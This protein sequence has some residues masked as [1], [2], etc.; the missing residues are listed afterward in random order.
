MVIRILN[1]IVVT[2]FVT[3][4]LFIT[5]TSHA[6]WPCYDQ[7]L[8]HTG[9]TD[10]VVEYPFEPE[11]STPLWDEN[12][13]EQ[14]FL[15]PG[16]P[17]SNG[18]V[19]I[20]GMHRAND[21]VSTFDDLEIWGLNVSDGSVK[22]HKN[23]G[24]GV[25]GAPQVYDNYVIFAVWNYRLSSS[26]P[27]NTTLY[28][29]DVNTGAEAWSKTFNDRKGC[30]PAVSDGKIVMCFL[31]KTGD[32]PDNFALAYDLSSKAELWRTPLN[33]PEVH[34]AFQVG[35]SNT[36]I[37][38]P[39]IY[40]G[41][42]YF[43][44]WNHARCLD[45]SDGH[46]VW[47]VSDYGDVNFSRLTFACLVADGKFIF[48]ESYTAARSGIACYALDAVDGS[49]EWIWTNNKTS[50][51]DPSISYHDGKIY[52]ESSEGAVV[53]NSSNGNA[54]N[55]SATFDEFNF[56]PVIDGNGNVYENSGLFTIFNSDLSS[57]IYEF[58]RDHGINIDRSNQ[59]PLAYLDNL[60][61]APVSLGNS[62]II[63]LTAFRHDITPPVAIIT[64]PSAEELSNP[65]DLITIK[66]TAT[67]FNLTEWKLEYAPHD[68][69][70]N[71]TLI[72]SGTN[73][74]ED[75]NLESYWDLSTIGDGEWNITLTVTDEAGLSSDD[76]FFLLRDYTPP[77]SV[78][79]YP[80]E[81]DSFEDLSITITGT[82]SDN[83]QLDRVQVW[84]SE[85]KQWHDA[86]GAET[87][88]Y[89]WT[90][91]NGCQSV[92][93]KSRAIDAMGNIESP[94]QEVTVNIVVNVYFEAVYPTS[95]DDASVVMQ[96]GEF[97]RKVKV[98]D[99]IG[100]PVRDARVYYATADGGEEYD[101]TDD[102]GIATLK[103]D[104]T[105]LM[106]STTRIT[107]PFETELEIT[108]IRFY[109]YPD[110]CTF[111][112]IDPLPLIPVTIIPREA[113]HY[114]SGGLA[115]SL[116]AGIT[117]YV[118]ESYGGGTKISIDNME[119]V[120]LTQT[121]DGSVGVGVSA[122]PE[123]G[124]GIVD[125]EAKVGAQLDFIFLGDQTFN[126]GEALCSDMD[127]SSCRNRRLAYSS[128]L[129]TALARNAMCLSNPTI[130][131]IIVL[132]TATSYS[133]YLEE[134][135]GRAGLRIE[136]GGNAGAGVGFESEQGAEA[137]GVEL[138]VLDGSVAFAFLVG[139]RMY[140]QENLT[141][142]LAVQE[143]ETSLNALSFNVGGQEV[144]S[145]T[146]FFNLSGAN[147]YFQFTEEVIF[148][149]SMDPTAFLFS[150]SDGEETVSY[151][152]EDFSAIQQY[153]STSAGNLQNLALG[154]AD[155]PSG[156]L[157]LGM[158]ACSHE[159]SR[160]VNLLD[161][162]PYTWERTSVKKIKDYD[163]TLSLDFNIQVITVGGS[164]SVKYEEGREFLSEKGLFLDGQKHVLSEYEYD[165]YVR[166]DTRSLSDM[167]SDSFS[168]LWTLLLDTGIS[169]FTDTVGS[170]AAWTINTLTG[171]GIKGI[172]SRDAPSTGTWAILSGSD[173][174]I[175]RTTDI[176]II[177]YHPEN[178]PCRG[179]SIV[180]DCF[181]IQPGDLEILKTLTLETGYGLSPMPDGVNENQ[182][183]M[184]F[185]D[186]TQ[187]RWTPVS[188]GTVSTE[189]H[190]VTAGIDSLCVYAVGA[191]ITPPVIN[192]LP[193]ASEGFTT[194]S[195]IMLSK[196]YDEI[197]EIS[198]NNVKVDGSTTAHNYEVEEKMLRITP[199]TPLSEG[200]HTV[201]IEAADASG[202][203]SELEKTITC[204]GTLP[205]A[206]ITYPAPGEVVRR[207]IDIKGTAD[208]D[209]FLFYTLKMK[210]KETPGIWWLGRP[211]EAPVNAGTL[212]T[213]DTTLIPDDEYTL[214]LRVVDKAGNVTMVTEDV[215][216]NN[217]KEKHGIILY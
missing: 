131:E 119:N 27:E 176:S 100:N 195:A 107:E 62:D 41:K 11:W 198:I 94:P 162:V 203:S 120:S 204:D 122:G 24:G 72:N 150:I 10:S 68:D 15:L 181:D 117:G 8:Q 90:G 76:S 86:D 118:A 185:W 52:L 157:Q 110:D 88:S 151:R 164:A 14:T 51:P 123:F 129:V 190:S 13:S 95:H 153:M 115:Q 170:T 177:S 126:F 217:T 31:D 2:L 135:S 127:N 98:T 40:N 180:G 58:D 83:I 39:C 38:P 30:A 47:D 136:A 42:V 148:N 109:D 211:S 132:L 28:V 192:M 174:S 207:T 97:L 189:N 22:W 196:I 138:S 91:I 121:F 65:D 202:N 103:V 64:Q 81:G 112:P 92:T 23:V 186:E 175:P 139:M 200:D 74:R 77:Q 44:T 165:T 25:L 113:K 128:L 43:T 154:F 87:W 182:L 199:E 17:V 124:M 102:N 7:N 125:A 19:A 66:G 130:D 59:A 3:A 215:I 206:V 56:S 85:S 79:T 143:I 208:D 93:F 152:F 33:A 161:N 166:G 53:L 84:D 172:D 134:Q 158:Q 99:S 12:A 29:L 26:D 146:E 70:D 188:G 67:D 49:E 179:L 20:M 57:E 187:N 75:Q 194:P 178:D 140:H 145:A 6:N 155:N 183:I 16:A 111:T 156:G 191:D 160:I 193:P 101:V 167:L 54:I 18:S 36:E 71:R 48:V 116:K 9:Y 105:D 214:E 73:Y 149:D 184:F 45:I 171:G 163:F 114:W 21:T 108:R 63:S 169:C 210:G 69:P 201:Y 80:N 205:D 5:N 104:S 78:I 106:D 142:L 1:L 37:A 4:F 141:G 216:V 197:S 89:D 82:A 50:Y 212:S 168:G 46:I 213:F 137:P 32:T 133:N 61:L 209:N 55:S 96:G 144:A 173:H 147:Q 35:S 159:L 60:I 34:A